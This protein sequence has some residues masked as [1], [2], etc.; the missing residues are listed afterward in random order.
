M[1]IVK[2]YYES[3][4]DPAIGKIVSI[5]SEELGSAGSQFTDND[6]EAL[7]NVEPRGGRVFVFVNGSIAYKGYLRE[8]IIVYV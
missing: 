1:I 6:G 3:S 5:G 2:V 8:K 4:D 7:F